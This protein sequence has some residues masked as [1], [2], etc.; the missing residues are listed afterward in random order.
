M[1]DV[2][3]QGQPVSS[4]QFTSD[5]LPFVKKFTALTSKPVL[6]VCNVA[7]NLLLVGIAISKVFDCAKAHTMLKW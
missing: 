1:L 7:E 2:L 5:E 4:L 3:H 6:Y